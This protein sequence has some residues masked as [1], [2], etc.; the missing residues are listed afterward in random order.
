[1]PASSAA[2]SEGDLKLFLGLSNQDKVGRDD[3]DQEDDDEDEYD[4]DDQ[5]EQRSE[6]GSD[7]ERDEAEEGEEGDDGD[8][9]E[10]DEREGGGDAQSYTTRGARDELLTDAEIQFK[11]T[12][13]LCELERLRG[14]G[15][16]L[17]R[18]YTMEDDLHTM[19]YEAKAHTLHLEQQN[20]INALKDGL[21]LF[22]SSCEFANTR[23]GPFLN[24]TNWGGAV[25]SD[26]DRGKYNLTLSKL[27]R[28]YFKTSQSS[29]PE[30]E[31]AFGL[32]SSAAFHHFQ[33]SHLGRVVP[34][35]GSGLPR[36][37]PSR[38]PPAADEEDEVPP[39]F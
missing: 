1:M 32:L 5:D 4:D 12:A 15:C 23:Y 8:G 37:P 22:A 10:D 7:D 29:N 24:L 26:L 35:G 6:G 20:S 9:F 3:D 38:F 34:V 21:R 39:T 33:R 11:K 27:S 18:E 16:R 13:I 36:A 31:L 19:E 17:T 25:S 14:L 2:A 30:M 28:K